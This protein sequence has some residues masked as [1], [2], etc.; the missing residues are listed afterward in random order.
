[1]NSSLVYLVQTDTTIGFLSQKTERL[2]M[3]KQRDP[4]KKILQTV[5]SL[6]T[7]QELQRV[8]KRFKNRVRRAKKT[9]FIYPNKKA[10]RV[11]A[12]GDHHRFLK[13]FHTLYSTSA[14]LTNKKFC[15]E[16]AI[17][18]SDVVLFTKEPF[19]EKN[20]SVI[21]K[22]GKKKLIKIR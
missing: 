22:L 14:N 13:K 3:A 8:P 17:E 18:K 5:D 7:L 12:Q 16:T 10:F 20:A 4:K 6:N 2:S 9:T 1:L 11:V 19:E 21:L 15:L